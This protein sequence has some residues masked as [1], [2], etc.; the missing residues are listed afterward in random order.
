VRGALA[1]LLLLA[2][3]A[4][5][6]DVPP[7][8]LPF[9]AD[10][11]VDAIPLRADG[12]PATEQW[13][14]DSAL[15][16]LVRNV[17]QPTIRAVLP[18]P[19]IATGAA[20][21]VVPGGGFVAV[22]MGKE[23]M[24]TA[25][26]LAAE[27]IAAFV[28]K[29]RTEETPRNAVGF[30]AHVAA[31]AAS[32]L[33]QGRDSPIPGEEAALEDARAALALVHDRADAWGIDRD[34]IGTLGFS[35]GAITVLNTVLADGTPAPAFAGLIYGRT[36]AADPPEGAPP[37]FIAV[38]ADDP[39]FGPGDWGLLDSWRAAGLPVEF[40][41]YDSGGHAF[42]MARRGTPSDLWFASFLLWLEA[43]GMR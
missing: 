19:A 39:L 33:V 13:F 7:T 4:A 23:G 12:D 30:G 26:A 38:A 28:V 37:L 21:I 32:F 41:Y 27:G 1:F 16:L 22:D 8:L 43:R 31:G 40:H 3:P 35:A 15:D 24:E 42:G 20:V 18:N 6:Q 9:V 34:R 36:P 10:A 5:A 11:T 29:Y 14:G 17:T 25:R 2:A